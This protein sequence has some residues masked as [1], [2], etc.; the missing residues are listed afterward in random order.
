MHIAIADIHVT[1]STAGR[2]SFSWEMRGL[3]IVDSLG[4][5]SSL[6]FADYNVDLGDSGQAAIP[7]RSFLVGVPPK[8]QIS[9]SFTAL[10]VKTIKLKNPLRLRKTDPR[11]V[12]HPNLRFSEQ[13]ISD[14]RPRNFG[15]LQ[16]QQFII[17]PFIYNAKNQTVEVLQKAQGTITFPASQQTGARAP[18]TGS[19]YQKMVSRLLLN[20]SV[21]SAWTKP[22]QTLLKRQVSQEFPLAP[23]KPM[24]TFQIGD[25]HDSINEGAIKENGIIKI[26]GKDIIGLLGSSL[27]MSQLALYGSHKGELPVI[28]P[29]MGDLPDGVTEIP[30]MRFDLNGNGLVDSNDYILAYVTGGSDWAFDTGSGHYYYNLNRYEDYRHYWLTSKTMGAA[31]SLS[32]MMPVSALAAKNLTSFQNHILFK[33]PLYLSLSGGNPAEQEEGG[34]DWYWQEIS[35][36]FTYQAVLPQIDTMGP[37]QLKFN[38]DNPANIVTFAE[39]PVCTTCDSTQWHTVNYTG[40]R[41][42]KIIASATELR[43]LEFKYMTDLDMSSNNALTVFSPESAGIVRYTLANVPNERVY[44]IRIGPSETL[45]LIDTIQGQTGTSYSWTDTAGKG[46]RYFICRQ[47]AFQPAPSLNA[48]AAMQSSAMAIHDLRAANNP[49]AN[50]ADYMVIT[51]PNFMGPAQQLV[52]HK[53]NIGRFAEP[54]VID[55]MDIYREFSGGVIDPAALRN[56]LIYVRSQ[57]GLHPDYVVLMGKGNYNYKQIG[58][59]EPVYIPVAEYPSQCIEDYF[60][61]LDEGDDPS[62]DRATPDIFIGRLPCTTPAQAAQMVQKTIDFDNPQTADFGA[63][64]DRVV[65]VSDDD[66][67]GSQPDPLG[68]QHQ[69]SS[70]AIGDLIGSLRPSADIHKVNLFEYPWNEIY[71]KPEA[72]AA[73]LD[74]INSGAAFVNWFGHGS[75]TLWADEHILD[76]DALAN[77]HN[78]KEYPLISSFSCCVGHF[79]QPQPTYSPSLAEDMIFAPGSGAIATIAATRQAFAAD[80]QDLATAFFGDMFDSTQTG[81]TFGQAYAS[82]KCQVLSDNS[83]IYA[84]FGDP[85]LCPVNS[86]RSVSLDII[87][88]A[89]ASIDTL[90]ALQSIT[91]RGSIRMNTGAIDANYGSAGKPASVQ[92]TI[93]NPNYQTTRKDGGTQS[94]PTYEMPGSPVFSGLVSI[95]NGTF[96]QAVYLPRKV[97]FNTPG[98][99]YFPKVIAYT[100]QD[101]DNALGQKNIVF[102]GSMPLDSTAS[103][104]GGPVIAIRPLL[105]QTIS[106]S[107]QAVQALTSGA[108]QAILPFSCEIDVSDPSGLDVVGTGPDEGLTMEIP[109]EVSRQSINSKFSFSQGSFTKGSAIINFTQNMLPSGTYTMTITAQDLVGNVSRKN[110]TLVVS[111]TQSLAMSQ[112]FNF[113]NPMKMGASTAFYFTLSYNSGVT[114]TIKLYTLSGKLLRVF[115]SAYTGEVFDG[116]DQIGNLLGP[117]VYLYQ[118]TAVD[119]SQAQP[120]TVK[121]PIQKLVVHPPR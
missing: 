59:T 54:K 98:A 116:R 14:A 78:S 69:Q 30:L 100:W 81:V 18:T 49:S 91:V 87:N 26:M 68:D 99:Q 90:K 32:R 74:D 97:T 105:D 53:K 40:N 86:M 17:K 25:G 43:Q 84:M 12:R 27:P 5:P 103:D 4:K 52:N 56:F 114:S 88:K 3:K 79:D 19:D 50:R 41:T 10:S 11:I 63:W 58:I 109:G 65:L 92:I 121:S 106:S 96:E 89:G 57:W 83:K 42:L 39:A 62:T 46:I 2:F 80:N 119:N 34:L 118:V 22:A 112:V 93:L 48:Q 33:E 51:H 6:S 55:I 61:Y 66:M 47:S 77:L 29:G 31:A 94:N 73:L 15:R 117:K 28:A 70:D 36:Q 9:I 21:A 110:F 76:P 120:V 72:R 71:Y 113:P 107:A 45:Q 8:G 44:I 7:A 24:I 23:T 38:I 75:N 101:S 111:Q 1:E 104:T 115:N 16:A 95:K 85:S 64:R 13:W 35:P 37:V 82:A 102:S 108:I 20:Y 67:Q 60:A